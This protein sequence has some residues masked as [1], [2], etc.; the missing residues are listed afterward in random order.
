M[1]KFDTSSGDQGITGTLGKKRIPKNDPRI[2]AVGAVDEA[3]ESL[4][5]AR[6][7]SKNPELNKIVKEIQLD[8]YQ[9]MSLLVVEKPDPKNFPD[10][11]RSRLEWLEEIISRFDNEISMPDGFIIPGESLSS[12][13]FG[14]ARTVVRRAEREVVELMNA[15]LLF[16]EIALPY[17]NRLSSFC[18]ILELITSEIPP[19]QTG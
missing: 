9:I 12:A 15:D 19:T 17:L 8:L 11:E 5:F 3:T 1:S 6:A 2:R 4:G 10:L 14:L 16:S 13:A 7:M 18:F